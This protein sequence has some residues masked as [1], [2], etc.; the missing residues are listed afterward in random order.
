[1]TTNGLVYF[2]EDT[3]VNAGDCLVDVDDFS[4][5]GTW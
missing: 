4:N 1:V 5:G 2:K 3:S